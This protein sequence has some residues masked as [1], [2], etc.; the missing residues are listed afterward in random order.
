V[1]VAKHPN[2]ADDIFLQDVAK[3]LGLLGEGD[4]LNV[5]GDQYGV[6]LGVACAE[7]GIDICHRLLHVLAK[8][9]GVITHPRPSFAGA[10]SFNWSSFCP[11]GLYIINPAGANHLSS[12]GASRAYKERAPL[13]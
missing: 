11:N 1:S 5:A 9:F 2:G 4:R 7:H 8:A 10:T 12:R 3:P 13:S 6:F